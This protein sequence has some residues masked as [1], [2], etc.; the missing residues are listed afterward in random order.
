MMDEWEQEVIEEKISLPGLA[1]SHKDCESTIASILNEFPEPDVPRHPQFFKN[2]SPKSIAWAMNSI[3][4]TSPTNLCPN[5]QQSQ[6]DWTS[7]WAGMN[8]PLGMDQGPASS[9]GK[10]PFSYSFNSPYPSDILPPVI[11]DDLDHNSTNQ[12]LQELQRQHQ[13]SNTVYVMPIFTAM[14]G[15]G[16]G[17]KGKTLT[18]FDVFYQ[19]GQRESSRS[20]RR[21]SLQAGGGSGNHLCEYCGHRFKRLYTL[22]TH[23]RVHTGAKPYICEI[24]GKGF[25]Q[26]GTKHNHIRAIHMQERPFECRFCNKTFSHKST[27]QVHIRTHTKEKP[28]HCEI[29]QK[30]FT[31]RATCLKHQSVHTGEKPYSCPACLKSFA[32]KSNLKRHF[33]NI[34]HTV[35]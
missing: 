17:S 8:M 14:P 27:L 1:S 33:N 25:R 9:S 22:N 26:S 34:H 24:C 2:M 12:L 29:C 20:S 16:Y 32:Q 31:D 28:Y 18:P 7:H 13:N 21:G 5:P 23:M 35:I 11:L 15:T 30:R 19:H 3:H 4:S 10:E 6:Y